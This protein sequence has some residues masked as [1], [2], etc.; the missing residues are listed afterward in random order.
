LAE[1]RRLLRAGDDDIGFAER[2]LIS[3]R[4]LAAKLVV[5]DERLARLQ[6]ARQRLGIDPDRA[7][8][9]ADLKCL[10]FQAHLASFPPP[11]SLPA[12]RPAS[13]RPRVSLA[14]SRAKCALD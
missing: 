13:L 8:T 11:P 12:L 6:G 4:V 10:A 3:G 1:A 9:T 5:N 7:V 2:R 14:R